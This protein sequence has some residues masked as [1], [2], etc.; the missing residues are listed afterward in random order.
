VDKPGA[1]ELRQNSARRALLWRG[2]GLGDGPLG[3]EE[4]RGRG[5]ARNAPGLMMPRTAWPVRLR[6]LLRAIMPLS[7]VASE[8]PPRQPRSCPAAQGFQELSQ[9]QIPEVLLC[10][11]AG[12]AA[13]VVTG[14]NSIPTAGMGTGAAIG[15]EGAV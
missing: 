15:V 12:D 1:L 3:I 7:T 11:A 2:D 13:S 5:A 10:I 6:I 14:A 4:L 9:V 8:H